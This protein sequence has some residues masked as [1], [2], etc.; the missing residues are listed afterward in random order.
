MRVELSGFMC[1]L[2]Y[3]KEVVNLILLLIYN[4]LVKNAFL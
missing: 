3:S 4:L 2:R 1:V